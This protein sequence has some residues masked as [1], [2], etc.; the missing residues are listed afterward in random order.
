M[1]RSQRREWR[2]NYPA[3]A[4]I[5]GA[6]KTTK[7]FWFFSSEKNTLPSCSKPPDPSRLIDAG[8]HRVTT[9]Q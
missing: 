1:Q 7:V 2:E 9:A 6:A 3:M 5:K 8:E 4:R